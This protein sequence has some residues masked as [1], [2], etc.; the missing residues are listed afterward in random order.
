MK[1]YDVEASTIDHESS[2]VPRENET[3]ALS[4][5]L[6]HSRWFAVLSQVMTFYIRS[7]EVP[8]RL[9][10]SRLARHEQTT[11]RSRPRFASYLSCLYIFSVL[12]SAI[13]PSRLSCYNPFQFYPLNPVR[14]AKITY[15]RSGKYSHARRNLLRVCYARIFQNFANVSEIWK[16]PENNTRKLQNIYLENIFKMLILWEKMSR[17]CIITQNGSFVSFQNLFLSLALSNPVQS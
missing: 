1:A 17:N 5:V 8:P 16:K 14:V 4:T 15:N 10:H 11:W 6:L 12:S 3:I 2:S 9:L 13:S 7:V